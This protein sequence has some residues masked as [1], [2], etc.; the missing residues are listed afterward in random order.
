LPASRTFNAAE[1]A[2]VGAW[3]N[4]LKW[5]ESNPLELEEK[6]RSTLIQRIQGVY[7]KAV[8]RMRFYSEIWWVLCSF[9]L[10]SILIHA[11]R[12]MSYV[13]N[14]SVGKHEDA[15]NILKEGIKANPARSVVPSVSNSFCNF[16]FP[17]LASSSISRTPKYKKQ[18]RTKKEF[19]PRLINSLMS[20]ALT[21]RPSRL[22][23]TPPIHRLSQM[24]R[25]RH[26]PQ[27][28]QLPVSHLSPQLG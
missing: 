8:I 16:L 2:L 1:R 12:Y 24:V 4:Y 11:K 15:V 7:R 18:E 10:L 25:P 3:K 21:L 5:E 22:G 13:W 23:S 6:D 26:F 17:L 9:L 19:S 28:H 14:N 20:S 27:M